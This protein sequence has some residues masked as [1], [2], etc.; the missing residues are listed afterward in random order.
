MLNKRGVWRLENS[1]RRSKWGPSKRRE[2]GGLSLLCNNL[3]KYVSVS[4][5]LHHSFITWVTQQ[6]YQLLRVSHKKIENLIGGALIGTGEAVKCVKASKRGGAYSGLVL[7][8]LLRAFFIRNHFIRN[9]HVDR[10]NIY[11]TYT[12]NEKKLKELF[13]L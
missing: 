7:P 8:L 13:M 4:S 10:R 12:T 5:H 11:G 9:L 2:V 6:K 1:S 3:H